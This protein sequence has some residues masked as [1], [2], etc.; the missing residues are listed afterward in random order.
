MTKGKQTS[1]NYKDLSKSQLLEGCSLCFQNSEDHLLAAEMLISSKLYGM[2]SSHI[3]LG[4][5]ELCKAVILKLTAI[6]SSAI[7]G[8]L[9]KYFY[10]HPPKHEKLKKMVTFL[11]EKELKALSPT[12]LFLVVGVIILLLYSSS[13]TSYR[14]ELLERKFNESKNLGFYVD[15][16]FS[17]KKWS[18]P[19][20]VVKES[21]VMTLFEL[22]KNFSALVKSV[23]L[24]ETIDQN[25]VVDLL[26]HINQKL[27]N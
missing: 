10:N 7:E 23:I 6:D 16:D 4:M 18:V 20:A 17:S 5:E 2:S 27:T 13:G 19:N 21:D 14:N 3:I 22:S 15:F 11:V 26:Q 12:Q 24:K 8:D 9:N 1:G 25:L